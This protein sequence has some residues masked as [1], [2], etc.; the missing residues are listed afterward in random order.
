M[1]DIDKL[2][3]ELNEEIIINED[4]VIPAALSQQYLVVKKQMA[5][6]QRQKDALTKQINQKDTEINILMQNLIAIESKAAQM[7][8]KDAAVKSGETA[9][10]QNQEAAAQTPQTNESAISDLFDELN[11]MDQDW[12]VEMGAE[13]FEEEGEGESGEV[14]DVLEPVESEEA[15]DEDLNSDYIFAIKVKDEDEDEDIIAKVYRNEDDA[16]WKIRVVQG[17]EDPLEAMQFDPDME[18]I[19]IMERIGEL[20]DE[21]EEIPMEKYKELLDNKAEIDAEYDWEEEKE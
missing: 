16:F 19:D 14:A 9:K 10:P 17:S 7:Q 5:D 1:A 3:E 21:V 2:I 15:N 4:V 18:F 20:Y 8:G 13:E 6:K 12:L 11:E